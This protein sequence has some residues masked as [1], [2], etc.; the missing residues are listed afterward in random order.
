VEDDL[1][2]R[3]R[4][5]TP[6]LGFYDRMGGERLLN[7]K[8]LFDGAYAWRDLETLVTNGREAPGPSTL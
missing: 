8:G 4:L 1:L 7:E 2:R 3:G 5:S 6:T